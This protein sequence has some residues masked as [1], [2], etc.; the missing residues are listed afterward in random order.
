MTKLFR[1]LKITFLLILGVQA[2]YALAADY[3]VQ[4]NIVYHLTKYIEWPQEK[5][6]GDFVIGIIG[7]TPLT[8]SLKES[9]ASR[10]VGNNRIVVRNYS[11]DESTFNCNILFV[12]EDEV[13]CLKR[14]ANVT[15]NNSVLVITEAEGISSK[16]YCVNFVIVN[17]HLKLIFNK[18]NIEKRNLKIASELLSLGTVVQ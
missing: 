9:I 14:I 17:N 4:A 18:G 7:D 13:R 3:S 8:E 11:G 2:A 12:C 10:T 15:Q 16:D 6:K 1:Y 5:R